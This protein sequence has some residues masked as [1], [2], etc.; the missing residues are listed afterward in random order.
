MLIPYNKLII[1]TD[2]HIASNPATMAPKAVRGR[3]LA[4]PSFG[5]SVVQTF[6]SAENRQLITAVGLFAVSLL[7]PHNLGTKANDVGDVDWRDFF[8]Q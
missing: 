7:Q 6:K 1:Y 5:Q 4:E 8:A 3:T 2:R